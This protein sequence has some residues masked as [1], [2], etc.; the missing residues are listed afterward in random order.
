MY[1][2]EDEEEFS[3]TSFKRKREKEEEEEEEEKNYQNEGVTRYVASAKENKNHAKRQKIVISDNVFLSLMKTHSDDVLGVIEGYLDPS[4]QVGLALVCTMFKKRMQR[5]IFETETDASDRAKTNYKTW[6]VYNCILHGHG[7]LIDWFV[8]YCEFSFSDKSFCDG[9]CNISLQ[10][11]WKDLMVL[12]CKVRPSSVSVIRALLKCRPKAKT[13]IPTKAWSAMTKNNEDSKFAFWIINDCMKEKW[14]QTIKSDQNIVSESVKGGKNRT[15]RF[16]RETAN[17]LDIYPWNWSSI[18]STLITGGHYETLVWMLTDE[19][20]AKK[21]RTSSESRLPLEI[22]STWAPTSR[23]FLLCGSSKSGDIRTLVFCVSLYHLIWRRRHDLE[24]SFLNDEH[25][26]EVEKHKFLFLEEAIEGGHLNILNLGLKE[27]DDD[28]D[29]E[30]DPSISEPFRAAQRAVGDAISQFASEAISNRDPDF[31]PKSFFAFERHLDALVTTANDSEDHWLLNRM[32]VAIRNGKFWIVKFFY[33]RGLNLFK[34]SSSPYSRGLTS[35]S[36]YS[37]GLGPWDWV[38]Y[39]AATHGELDFLKWMHATKALK[40]NDPFLLSCAASSS[41]VELLDWAINEELVFLPNVVLDTQND[42]PAN[43]H[44]FP[45]YENRG[46]ELVR[47]GS[48]LSAAT[49][50]DTPWYNER[51]DIESPYH[52][53]LLLHMKEKIDK[54]PYGAALDALDDDRA[55][56]T[57]EWLHS[58]GFDLNLFACWTKV[59]T[60]TI[61]LKIGNNGIF[62][63][64]EQSVLG[65]SKII[66]NKM[67]KTLDWLIRHGGGVISK[68]DIG[69][70]L[71]QCNHPVFVKKLRHELGIENQVKVCSNTEKETNKRSVNPFYHR[72]TDIS[73]MVWKIQTYDSS[74]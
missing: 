47:I 33:D 11:H 42:L 55:V 61:A 70:I 37:R 65:P 18:F 24:T 64:A 69:G 66:R 7:G 34:P 36:R 68:V 10:D 52:D 57:M 67:W 35:D 31:C 73:D 14:R 48:S 46:N 30:N 12:A 62:I 63:V 28:I 71:K 21:I 41:N 4:S 58:K 38:K 16:L 74:A 2:E 72:C 19:T 29:W 1:E 60:G 53:E 45:I 13:K 56:K 3:F 50:Y 25:H 20:A 26:A 39:E 9:N 27:N 5:R 15:H 6:F 8:S 59:V 40:K 22:F 49:N 51:V 54:N 17:H 23:S 43:G 44:L 32:G